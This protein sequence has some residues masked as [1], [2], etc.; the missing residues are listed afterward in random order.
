ML[1]RYRTNKIQ[2]QQKCH[3]NESE[4]D[5]INTEKN[6]EKINETKN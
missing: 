3:K 2:N 1:V 4:I 5:E 6:N